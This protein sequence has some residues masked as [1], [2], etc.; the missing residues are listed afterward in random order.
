MTATPSISELMAGRSNITMFSVCPMTR[1]HH[2]QLLNTE[3][4][5][6]AKTRN[7]NTSFL[8]IRNTTSQYPA[9]VP[10]NE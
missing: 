3:H 8:M 10:I 1:C 7:T 9:S 2:H 6:T 4:Y 5:K